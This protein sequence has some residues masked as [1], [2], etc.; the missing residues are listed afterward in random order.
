MIV[1]QVRHKPPTPLDR[2]RE[3]V[4]ACPSF[5]SHVNLSR[6]VRLAACAGVNRIIACGSTK[7]DPKISRGGGEQVKIER[8][9]TLKAVLKDRKAD[10]FRLVGL[11]QSTGSKSIYDYKFQRKSLLVIGHERLGLTEELLAM[12]HDLIEIP[13]HGLP[14]SHNVATATT[15]AVYEYCRQYPRG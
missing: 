2:P 14:Y 4:I 12:I 15:M 11:E 6:I 7:I 10:G 3:L 8:H 9:R 13:V 5:R 1:E